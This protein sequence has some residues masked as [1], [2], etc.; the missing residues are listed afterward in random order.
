MQERI[1]ASCVNLLATLNQ[2]AFS[3]VITRAFLLNSIVY[4]LFFLYKK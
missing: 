2:S 4:G 3:L 1:L